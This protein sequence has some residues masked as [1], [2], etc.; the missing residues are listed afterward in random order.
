L[1][2]CQMPAVHWPWLRLK[3]R[4]QNENGDN[5]HPAGGRATTKGKQE[6]AH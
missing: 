5:L 3:R 1:R 4:V 6:D 2:D